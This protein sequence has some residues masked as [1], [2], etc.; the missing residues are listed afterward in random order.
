[1]YKCGA[2]PCAALERAAESGAKQVVRGG[3]LMT[4]V[5]PG[6]LESRKPA[7]SVRVHL[8]LAALMWS[9]VGVA[10]LVVGAIWG[11]R[12]PHAAARWLLAAAVAA[13][14]VKSR[15]IL[16]RAARRIAA[17]IES[18]GDGRCVGGFL[19]PASW[20]LVAAMAGTGRLLRSGLL[21]HH[22]VGLLYTAVGAALLISSRLLWR[23]WRGPAHR[24]TRGR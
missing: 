8:L 11:W 1:M 7:A 12:V 15:L 13:G 21:S 4:V 10:L 19:S 24:D 17:R 6:W 20:L 22:L 9:A 2:C 16:D 5:T 23:R 18:R 14:V 3:L